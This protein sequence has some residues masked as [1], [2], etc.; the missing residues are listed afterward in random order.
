MFL[1]STDDIRRKM[2]ML[3][4]EEKYA[5]KDDDPILYQYI[6]N[7]VIDDDISFA[8][9]MSEANLML[10]FEYEERHVPSIIAEEHSI[11]YNYYFT[12]VFHIPGLMPYVNHPLFEA[13]I[14]EVQILKRDNYANGIEMIYLPYSRFAESKD[15]TDLDFGNQPATLLIG[16]QDTGG[17]DVFD[18]VEFLLEFRISM[19]HIKQLIERRESH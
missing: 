11:N 15:S 8:D 12:G 14:N 18:M 4:I 2:T 13:F 9:I 7:H 19:N 5:I 17:L 1:Y 10:D 3:R 6:E 16:L